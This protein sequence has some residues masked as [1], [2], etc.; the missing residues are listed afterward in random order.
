M[1]LFGLPDVCGE[2]DKPFGPLTLPSFPALA[3]VRVEGRSAASF[4]D[5]DIDE[6]GVEKVADDGRFLVEDRRFF[7][8]AIE[9]EP[10]VWIF[11]DDGGGCPGA[12][13]VPMLLVPPPPL[14]L[15]MAAAEDATVAAAASVRYRRRRTMMRYC[16]IICRL[17][18]IPS[19]GR[20]PNK[21]LLTQGQLH[22]RTASLQVG[23]QGIA[24]ADRRV[25]RSRSNERSDDGQYL[26]QIKQCAAPCTGC[27]ACT[28]PTWHNTYVFQ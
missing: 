7:R 3:A 23:G 25:G 10:C 27:T 26:K 2:E 9:D 15:L 4:L 11:A 19:K 21:T 12:P 18:R 24:I 16:N 20:S 17:L 28:A 6:T 1:H 8:R 13:A 22:P 14:L 5:A